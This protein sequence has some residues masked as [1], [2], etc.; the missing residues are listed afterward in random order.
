MY[1]VGIYSGRVY[2]QSDYDNNKIHECCISYAS[3][4]EARTAT[5][6]PRYAAAHQQCVGCSQC[7]ES[8]RASAYPVQ[9]P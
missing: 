3:R 7:P 5:K 2:S 4:S 6:T 9:I 8:A 1:R